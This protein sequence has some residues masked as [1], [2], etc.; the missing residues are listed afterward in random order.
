MSTTINNFSKNVLHHGVS[1]SVSQMV[2]TLCIL[3]LSTRWKLV[4]SFMLWPL[5]PWERTSNTHCWVSCVGPKSS[6]EVVGKRKI[7]ALARNQ[8]L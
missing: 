8:T 5:Y 4:V 2:T 1:Q 6:L 7:L 3:N